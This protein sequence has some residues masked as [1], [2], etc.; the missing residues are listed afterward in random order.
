MLAAEARKAGIAS[1]DTSYSQAT[2]F[3]WKTGLN[4][5]DVGE[6]RIGDALNRTSQ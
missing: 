3:D 6:V 2:V 1:E 4:P 5:L